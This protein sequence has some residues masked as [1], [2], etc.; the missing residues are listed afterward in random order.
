[1]FNASMRAKIEGAFDQLH[2][3]MSV[4][5]I[6]RQ[7]KA[8]QTVQNVQVG[9]KTVSARDESLINAYGIAG[10]IIT[11]EAQS[12][13]VPPVKL[14]TVEIDGQRYT[15]QSVQPKYLNGKLLF[16]TAYVKG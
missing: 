8:P 12:L 16:Y 6:F 3:L 15:L 11:F 4:P 7:A 13:T 5:A 2:S 10:K 14:D 1:M 9:F